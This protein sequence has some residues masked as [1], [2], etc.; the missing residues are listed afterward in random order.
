MTVSFNTIPSGN[1]IMVPLFYAEVDNSAAFT[2]G[3]NNVALLIGQ[4][5]ETGTAESEKPIAVSSAAMAKTLFGRG[6]MLA[7]M[8]EAYRGTDTLGTL[9]CIAVDD[10]EG[11]AKASAQVAFTGEASESGTVS[12]Y[13]GSNLIRVGVAAKDA[14]SDVCTAAAAA[15]NA[16][17]DLPV[18]AEA[19]D[20]T[21]TITARNAGTLGNGILVRKNVK[22]LINGEA[23]VTGLGVTITAM[24]GGATD[25][26]VTGII[27]AMGSEAYEYIGLP[28]CDAASLDAFKDI[29]NDSSGRWGPYQMLYGHVFSTK[30]GD[31]NTLLEFGKT[32]NDQHCTIFALEPSFGSWNPEAL[33]SVVARTKI[34]IDADPARPTQTGQLIGITGAPVGERFELSDRNTLL[35]NGIATLKDVSG[36]VQIERSITTYRVNSY[37]DTDLSYVD[38]ETLFTTAYVI[39]YLQGVITSKYGRHKLANDG[40]NFGPGQAIVTPGII[41]AELSVAYAKL[42]RDGI[43]E[44]AEKFD[45]YLAVERDSS[46]V[47]RMNVLFP[48]DY[49]NQLR[50]FALLNQF[51]LQYE[52][53]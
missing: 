2:P 7:R 10:A 40:T 48:P 23:D 8:V 16:Q 53:E 1:G 13:I 4:K 32:R 30:R 51:R 39:R 34:F 3:N 36:T 20:G 26:D 27:N 42:E 21:L 47:N 35:Q 46:N 33:A 9:Y 5:L 11:S 12:L 49:V 24:S 45:E 18:T 44:N 52:E 43:V 6:S 41:R 31:F 25:P 37:G 38:C 28:Y 22:G 17:G 19:E 50:V 15:I 14:A 29:M